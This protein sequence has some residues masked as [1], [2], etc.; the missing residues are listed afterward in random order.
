MPGLRFTAGPLAGRRVEV[1]SALLLGRQAAD[2][3]LDDPQVSRRHAA[4]RPAPDGGLELED[5]GSRNGTWVNG[6][7]VAGTVRLAPG[8]RV[9][10]GDT[11]FEV[12]GAPAAAGTAVEAKGAG[13]AAAGTVAGRRPSAPPP[14]PFD[15][16]PQRA[17]RRPRVA[18]RRLTPTL[19]SFG[20]VVATAVALVWY[21]AMR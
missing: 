13:P 6:T 1:T 17:P 7:R 14:L 10:L 15:P 2:L 3:T 12:E 4:L 21:F 8:D 16:P 9:Q 19:L 11:A 5:L 20:A 18:T